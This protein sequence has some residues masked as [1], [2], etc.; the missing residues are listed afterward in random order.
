M[1]AKRAMIELSPRFADQAAALAE[2]AAVETVL[3]LSLALPLILLMSLTLWIGLWRLGTWLVA[4]L[5]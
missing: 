4:L 5:A 3:P 1:L 2:D